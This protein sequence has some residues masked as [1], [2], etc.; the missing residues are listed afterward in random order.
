MTGYGT[1]KG[2][3][4][5]YVA[6]INDIYQKVYGRDATSDE[7]A[8]MMPYIDRDQ[9][10]YELAMAQAVAEKKAA[11]NTPDKIA[12]KKQDEDLTNAPQ[13]FDAVQNLFQSNLGRAATQD[14]LNHFGSL[15]ASGT[16]DPYQLQQFLQ[17]QPEYTTTQD[18]KMR[19]GLSGTMQTNDKNYFENSILP[20]IQQTFAKQGRTVDSSG[21]ANSA[22]QSA[23]QQNTQRE[24]FL[25]S[26]TASQY[27][28]RQANA[29]SDYANMIQNQNA[30]TNAGIN[31][32]YGNVQNS[33]KRMQDVQDFS[34]QQQAYNQYLAKYGKR[35]NVGGLVGG[36]A[37]AAIGSYGGPAGASIGYQIGSGLGQAGQNYSQGGSY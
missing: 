33:I 24:Q 17:Q 5:A 23:Q 27:Q 18:Q 3:P 13:H 34:I 15:L 6:P 32:Q 2:N 21:F 1:V 35:N 25:S 8:A 7:Q 29:Y 30:L 28:G 9:G 31:A 37:G 16:T 4:A 26:L 20:S 12:K 22:T 10:G 19:E 36:L 14:E 11:D